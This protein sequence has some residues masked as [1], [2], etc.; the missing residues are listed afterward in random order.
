[1]S[2]FADYLVTLLIP[3]AKAPSIKWG[4]SNYNA[5]QGLVMVMFLLSLSYMSADIF[6]DRVI[7][8]SSTVTL[9]FRSNFAPD[10]S[11]GAPTGFYN[12]GAWQSI[13]GTDKETGYSWPIKALGADF[14]GIQLITAN[15]INS[16]SIGDYI[17]NEIRQVTGPKGGM[18]N[19]LFQN[20]KI[21]GDLG[22]ADSQ[23]P[24]LIKRPWTIG[25]VNDLYITYWFKYELDFPSKLTREVPGAGWRQ[26][27]AVKTGGYLNDWRGDYRIS[28]TILKGLDG[29][30]YWQT[31]GDNVANGP[32]PRVDYWT[33]D[34][35]A[36]A[37]PVDKW[38]K[39][40]V[41][42]HRSSGSD[43]RFWVAVN[44]EV[45]ADYHGPNM[46]DYNLPITRIFPNNAYSGGYATV[47]SHH[48]GF[49]MWDGFPCGIGVSCYEK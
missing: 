14:S 8:P 21:K 44:G 49:E 36:V 15:P 16:A 26:M 43:G 7:A 28:V 20:V 25:D 40:E 39:F 42:W 30:L 4:N 19:E 29:Q 46:G 17:V 47:E 27:F 3:V 12:N 32:W 10:V 41:Y 38:S 2:G 5:K 22:Q 13:I 1:L 18:I 24:L 33:I 35:H 48:T 31:K 11:L 9:L 34:N 37:V 45:I 23:A 6:A